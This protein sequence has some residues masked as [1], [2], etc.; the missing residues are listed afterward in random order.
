MFLFYKEFA[1][2]SDV[3]D[4]MHEVNRAFSSKGFTFEV[5]ESILDCVYGI[6]LTEMVPVTLK[7]GNGA[8]YLGSIS[9]DTLLMCE[10]VN[11]VFVVNPD[12]LKIHTSIDDRGLNIK[13]SNRE[14]FLSMEDIKSMALDYA[15]QIM[16]PSGSRPIVGKLSV[17]QKG[18]GYEVSVNNSL[19]LLNSYEDRH[20]FRST[21][22]LVRGLYQCI[23]REMVEHKRVQIG[24]HAWVHVGMELPIV[25]Q[26]LD[27]D[28]TD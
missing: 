6:S 24:Q 1:D 5:S 15:F 8:S 3:N 2:D 12:F 20:V 28:Q 7:L 16:R 17:R 10:L 19:P 9:I 14:Q 21:Q 27:I 25:W 11:G 13:L 18:I 23:L 4:A 22:H 26:L